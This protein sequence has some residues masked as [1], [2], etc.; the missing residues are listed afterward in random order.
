[1]PLLLRIGKLSRHKP[2]TAVQRYLRAIIQN[3]SRQAVYIFHLLN[4]FYGSKCRKFTIHWFSKYK[5]K[6]VK[7]WILDL[8]QKAKKSRFEPKQ[9]GLLID[10]GSSY[11]L[12]RKKE[13]ELVLSLISFIESFLLHLPRYWRSTFEQWLSKSKR[14]LA[15]NRS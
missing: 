15:M 8:Y 2:N 11:D 9:N 5:Q 14:N 4:L 13:K 12:G 7:Q 6:M 1:M 3:L 10:Q